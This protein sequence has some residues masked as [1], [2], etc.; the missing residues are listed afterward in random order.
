M[1]YDIA[2]RRVLLFGGANLTTSFG[3]TWTWDGTNW[4]ELHPATVPHD[5]YAGAMA[6][7]PV[8][9]AMVMFG[10]YS[11]SPALDDTWVLRLTP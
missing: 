3:D 2:L 8:A 1:A 11:S 10:G 7:D 4:T 9:R 5:R 6:Y